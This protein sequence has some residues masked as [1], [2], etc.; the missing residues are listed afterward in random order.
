[1]GRVAVRSILRRGQRAGLVAR[2][3]VGLYLTDVGLR[4][5]CRGAGLAHNS[6]GTASWAASSC[7]LWIA[8]SVSIAGAGATL[9]GED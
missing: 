6:Y 3:T 9:Y 2:E 1:M 5:G 8:I 7:I 4:S